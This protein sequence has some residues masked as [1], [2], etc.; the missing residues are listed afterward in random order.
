VKLSSMF[1]WPWRSIRD[2]SARPARRG[3][4]SR[5]S[6]FT[7]L[8]AL[9]MVVAIIIVSEAALQNLATNGRRE[10]ERDMMWRGNQY[11]RAV[12]MFYR[13]T[14]HYPKTLEELEK[15][16]PQLH[17]LRAA[18]YK[19]PMN[20]D[21][22]SWGLIYIN[23][24]GQLIG[25][26]RY[27]SLQEM[28]LIDLNGGQL[29][30]A[31]QGNAAGASNGGF[32][33]PRDINNDADSQIATSTTSS[34]STTGAMGGTATG[35]AASPFGAGAGQLASAFGQAKP[36]GPVDGPVLGGFVTGVV[37]KSKRDSIKVYKGGKKYSEWEFI[38]NPLEDQAQALQNG[39][40]PQGAQPGQPGLPIANPNGGSTTGTGVT[41]G[42]GGTQQPDQNPSPNN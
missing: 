19:D 20:K 4:A 41:N 39:L 24:A 34:Q 16:Q 6:G 29:P 15:G 30:A 18:A 32:S 10:R 5:E 40:T 37:S 13:K 8:M 42:P 27:T 38:W 28:A 2:D 14:G 35:Q 7:Y 36:T 11:I 3:R 31:L 33:Q 9:F 25:S 22:G 21:D 17:F 1:R 26:S 23:G 12:R